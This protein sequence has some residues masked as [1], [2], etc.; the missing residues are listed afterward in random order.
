MI[1]TVTPPSQPHCHSLAAA[2]HRSDPL[3]LSEIC[4]HRG[5]LILFRP[6]QI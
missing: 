1:S 4:H 2:S 6:Y 5:D 3:P